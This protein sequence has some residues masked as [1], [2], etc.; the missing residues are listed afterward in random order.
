MLLL[1]RRDMFAN[2][3]LSGGTTECP[4]FGD[5]LFKELSVLAPRTMRIKI[6]SPTDRRHSAWVGGSILA[7][8]STFKQGWI[9]KEMYEESGPSIV[10]ENLSF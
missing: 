10:H 9:S 8:L 3:V 6:T 1:D 7:S 4:G 5:R 2:I